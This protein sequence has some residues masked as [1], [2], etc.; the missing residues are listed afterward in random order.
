M[1]VVRARERTHTLNRS[2]CNTQKQDAKDA[3]MGWTSWTKRMHGVDKMDTGGKTGKLEGG[4]IWV[5]LTRVE[6]I[7]VLDWG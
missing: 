3:Y 1:Y 6:K 2:G 5:G 4:G 7:M